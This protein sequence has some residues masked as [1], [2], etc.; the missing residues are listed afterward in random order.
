MAP[1]ATSYFYDGLTPLFGHIIA[2]IAR[3]RN[4]PRMR[5]MERIEEEVWRR[6]KAAR[7]LSCLERAS[8]GEVC[9][10]APQRIPASSGTSVRS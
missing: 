9:S 7:R 2:P 3:S 1:R 6:V 8:E 10:A 4:G 5:Q